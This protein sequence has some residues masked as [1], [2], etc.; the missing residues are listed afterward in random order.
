MALHVYTGR[1]PNERARIRG[2]RGEDAIDVAAGPRAA[3][4]G[5]LSPSR[6]L[7]DDCNKRK[8][9]ARGDEQRLRMVW[10]WYEPL[11]VEE[12]RRS[13]L[14][15][16]G[17]WKGLLARTGE[18]TLCCYCATAHRCHRRLLAAILVTAGQRLGVEVIDCGERP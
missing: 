3:F 8:R 13:W 7:N 12:M 18:I 16:N 6:D 5:A 1:L 10:S 4:D 15:C 17:V 9:A 2:Y 14:N 11:F